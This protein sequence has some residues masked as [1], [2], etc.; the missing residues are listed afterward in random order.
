MSESPPSI[1]DS[2]RS[3]QIA[4]KACHSCRRARL[5][6]DRS[7]PHCTKC[8]S[9][10]VECLGYGRLF[11][12]TGSVATRGKLAGQ[13]SSAAVCR[14]PKQ[15]EMVPFDPQ[16]PSPEGWG[17][18]NDSPP[19]ANDDNQLFF[20]N[21]PPAAP[22]TLVDPVFQDM[23]HSHRWYLNYFSSRVCMDLVAH[24]QPD[25]NPFRSLLQ[26]TN[27]HPFL[28]Q[29]IVAVSAAHMSNLA[30]P[31]LSP[32]SFARKEPPK[33]LLMDALVAKQKALQMMPSALQNIDSIGADV[34]LATVLFLVNV[35][36][37]ESGWQ[38]WRPHLEGAK[39]LL[40]MVQPY[41]SFDETL[42]D[43][44]M[45]DCYIYCT[46]SLSFNPSSPGVQPTFFAP[47][48]VQSML[49]RATN[50][51]F[52]CPAEVMDILR[53]AA[54]LLN[55]GVSEE[56]T[57]DE[58]ASASAILLKRA[59]NVDV[60]TWAQQGVPASNKASIQSRFVTGSTHRL[61]TCLYI[62]QS[63]PA[64][65]TRVPD[66]VCQALI[67][68]IYD[69]LLLMPDDD[70]NFKVTGWPTFIYGTTVTTPE[71]RA[72]VMDRLK[73]VAEVCPWGFLYSAIDTLQILWGLDTEGK[74]TT[75]WV[76]ALRDLNVDFLMV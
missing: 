52:S 70:P 43:Y 3:Q 21:K 49:S 51:F 27:V 50:H 75:N 73:R 32:T 16:G 17:L 54:E 69:T 18:F 14:L 12:W 23:S 13:S 9:R 39:R 64:L 19:G 30:R 55:T 36:L 62:I 44:I 71:R 35:E 15:G 8:S 28:K 74:T 68:E 33:R 5:R 34:I 20:P 60:F 45:S 42:R 25:T 6:C 47:S 1:S 48:Q 4:K 24:D 37:L 38:S 58:M 63:I 26:L 46:L 56:I 76:Q 10:G 57:D 65:T 40:N 59:Q 41:A 7:F 61:A 53:E 2:A 31:W 29:I 22:W 67:N 72:W 11:L 66:E